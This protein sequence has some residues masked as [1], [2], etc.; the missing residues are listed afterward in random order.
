M[1][2]NDTSLEGLA[3]EDVQNM[4]KNCPKGD[5]RV[6]AQ[7]GPK[8]PKHDEADEGTI[9]SPVL[10]EQ[11]ENVTNATSK[12]EVDILPEVLSNGT[13]SKPQVAMP[14]E[15]ISR[16]NSV[17]STK[18]ATSL[19]ASNTA[20]EAER[21]FRPVTPLQ[22][23]TDDLVITEE[24]DTVVENG[25]LEDT[26]FDDVPP[27]IRPPPVPTDD[28]HMESSSIAVDE[29]LVQDTVLDESLNPPTN[30]DDFFDDH[31]TNSLPS[32]DD[33]EMEDA[34]SSSTKSPGLARLDSQPSDHSTVQKKEES[35]N[36]TV[37]S[38]SSGED[39]RIP[40][41]DIQ[42]QMPIKPPSLFGD[43]TDS[44][45]PALPRK[46]VNNS[47]VEDANAVESQHWNGLENA[48]I[49]PPSLFDD[50][51]ES[52][53]SLPHAPPP[54]KPPRLHKQ[55]ISLDTVSSNSSSP[56]PSSWF[57]RES[58]NHASRHSGSSSPS[59]GNSSALQ[60][61]DQLNDLPIEPPDGA[62]DDMSS[63]PPA[64]PPPRSR[65]SSFKS[66][67]AV[68]SLPHGN[69]KMP[70]ITSPLP[71]PVKP[72][73]K[74]SK[75]RILPL[76]IRSKKG[77]KTSEQSEASFIGDAHNESLPRMGFGSASISSDVNQPPEDDMES[78]PPAP[79][80]PRMSPLT[81]ENLESIGDGLQPMKVV[82]VKPRPLC[83]STDE[84]RVITP[85]GVE[86]L[87]SSQQSPK[88]KKKS[89]RRHIMHMDEKESIPEST[90]SSTNVPTVSETDLPA[91]TSFTNLTPWEDDV[92][93]TDSSDAMSPPPLPP[94]MELWSEAGSAVAELALLDQILTLEDSSRS[95]NEH[96]SEGG[97][98][99]SAKR[100]W[101][102]KDLQ[103]VN[104]KSIEIHEGPV[105]S[106]SE[107]KFDLNNPIMSK[108]D[109]IEANTTMSSL[110]ELPDIKAERSLEL[111]P[112]KSNTS[113]NM[114]DTNEDSESDSAV[115]DFQEDATSEPVLQ[116]VS[117][118]LLKQLS[119]GH[120]TTGNLVKH[121]RPAPPIPTRPV[122]NNK[123]STIP[124]KSLPAGLGIQV[125]PSKPDIKPK[126]APQPHQPTTK[127]QKDQ[128]KLSSPVKEK[129]SKKLF[130]KGH[131]GKD[132][133]ADPN[134]LE[135]PDTSFE[136]NHDGRER[137]RSWT[138]RL[139]GFR[140]RSKSRDKSKDQENK[141]IEENRSRS[142]SPRRGLFSKA[143][144]SSP[145]PPPSAKK[146]PP[147]SKHKHGSEK[148][149]VIDK[150]KKDLTV[151]DTT[152]VPVLS[153]MVPSAF[154]LNKT[155][156]EEGSYVEGNNNKFGSLT[157]EDE[158]V[159]PVEE[160]DVLND[161]PHTE[162]IIST[163]QVE[164]CHVEPEGE[165]IDLNDEVQDLSESDNLIKSLPKEGDDM[166]KPDVHFESDTSV[167][168]RPLPPLPPPRE[169]Y[170]DATSLARN[171]DEKEEPAVEDMVPRKSPSKPPVPK[172]P[173]WI[174]SQSSPNT[175]NQRTVEELKTSSSEDTLETASESK[176]D[177]T[178]DMEGE[179]LQDRF[180][181][182]D[183]L[184]S[185]G[186]PTFKP[187]PPPLSL[188]ANAMP[189]IS[190]DDS[191][192][193][194]GS[195]K[196]PGPPQFKPAPPPLALKAMP[197]QNDLNSDRTLNAPNS[198]GPPRFKPAPPPID[199]QLK[200]KNIDF[201]HRDVPS[202]ADLPNMKPLP[203]IP[204]ADIMQRREGASVE[205]NTAQDRS[206]ENDS[207][208]AVQN[209]ERRKTKPL[210]PIPAG[211]IPKTKDNSYKLPLPRQNAEECDDNV[212]DDKPELLEQKS[213]VSHAQADTT[214][215][216]NVSQVA[217]P[218]IV[219]NAVNP[220]NA[221]N[222]DDLD[223]SDLSS[224]W[225]DTCSSTQGEPDL[226][227][228]GTKFARSASFSVGDVH[229]QRPPVAAAVDN[230]KKRLP[231][232]TMRPPPPMRRRS[233]SLPQLFPEKLAGA[234]SEG[235]GETD[236]W[237]TGN[238]QQLINSRNQEPDVDEGIIE[239]QVS[240]KQI[241][242]YA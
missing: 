153:P 213:E 232:A 68:V 84:Q 226:P 120:D 174:K 193:M 8:P 218:L 157:A 85:T 152:N 136:S 237:H 141:R 147:L 216:G 165:S 70:H 149:P 173:I 29:P 38:S 168:D 80:P 100:P 211:F 236:Y 128:Q 228:A 166:R 231:A 192:E 78:L 88:K 82:Q 112:V 198:P 221:S 105:V 79:P 67:D 51:L 161:E 37:E 156:F 130:S 83:L 172:K 131:K 6:V 230:Q 199:L 4:I 9:S 154:G 15:L 189:D 101:F 175:Q 180:D 239:V 62:D 87:H 210:P 75:K 205:L 219:Q 185:P 44:I 233:S 89:F 95:G 208:P 50:E 187:V 55:F 134:H 21:T 191:D 133:K 127:H 241:D 90:S 46:V 195:P 92:A 17:I 117:G 77:R 12:A 22:E 151:H 164:P 53:P 235:E 72:E 222:N 142:V 69:E 58:P 135:S 186:P 181:G 204:T 240:L 93:V 34:D 18:A 206:V 111:Q 138:K 203:P 176:E 98:T 16:G 126:A 109:S 102:S 74:N 86:P 200:N 215:D 144:R 132:K 47:I 76:R 196:S 1:S 57:G 217:E 32:L 110:Q 64:P 207:T 227:V 103:L 33:S 71:Q 188:R 113:F 91:D 56:V 169:K 148:G 5:V 125:L 159:S 94:E 179:D 124:R 60:I 242:P 202:V 45:P 28:R 150:T 225:D 220:V 184:P 20:Q 178:F 155:P 63:L 97:S 177:L 146:A 39:V 96:S 11:L 223:S 99:P 13:I 162:D 129:S 238:L 229:I 122:V 197:V 119:E 27:P 116:E 194:A 106:K 31:H 104:G 114:T 26:D 48:P 140:S 10:K 170:L 73:R 158:E 52:L 107:D 41:D 167:A 201:E 65:S 14:S 163:V 23:H 24:C 81:V 145:P 182:S 234:A 19:I 209:D 143:R 54:P 25:E 123:A 43:D 2:I 59:H 36:T 42:A 115:N 66:S 139:F 160:R 118:K 3:L 183:D 214:E 171:V 61:V 121:R 224:E 108:G 40:S 49:K 212:D 7:A 30:F 190:D 137:S 35:S